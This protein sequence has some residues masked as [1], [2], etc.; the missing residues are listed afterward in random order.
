[1]GNALAFWRCRVDS[2]GCPEDAAVVGDIDDCFRRR[3]GFEPVDFSSEAD[4]G[5]E[6]ETRSGLPG[7]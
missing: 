7:D 1:M 4:E 2:L 6:G 3:G 5:P